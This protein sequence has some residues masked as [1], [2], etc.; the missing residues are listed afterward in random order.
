[1]NFKEPKE[2]GNQITTTI[3]FEMTR[4]FWRYR[5]LFYFFVWRDI[6][7]KYKQTV[8]GAL[9]AII[10]P[11]SAMVV[12]TIFFGKFAKMPSEGAPYPVFSY[13]ALVPWTYFSSAVALAGNSLVGNSDLL[14]K[15][16]FPRVAIPGASVLSGLVDFFI[17]SIILLGLI[18]YYNITLSWKLLF[19]PVLVIPMIF[20]ALGLGLIFSSLNVRY[21]D[22]KYTVPFVMQMLLFITPIIYP[23]SILPERFRRI[24]ALNPL[25]GIIEAFR[26]TVL[27]N[28]QVD[29]SLLFFSVV[30]SLIIFIIGLIFFRKTEKSFADII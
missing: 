12:F 13:S 27:P 23:I 11:F 2:L 5:E 24:A 8:L 26:S 29:F 19:W 28:K 7:L 3:K 6:K 30:T 17:A 10:Q 25:T 22:I 20:L 15:V 4:E 14:T 21:R 16:Y 9:W 18:V 1:M